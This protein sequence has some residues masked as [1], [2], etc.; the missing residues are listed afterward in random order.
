MT[1][2]L[3]QFRANEIS[4]KARG[5][6]DLLDRNEEGESAIDA[7]HEGLKLTLENQIKIAETLDLIKQEFDKFEAGLDKIL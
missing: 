4:E 7:I 5:V 6:L 3:T 1:H 2:G